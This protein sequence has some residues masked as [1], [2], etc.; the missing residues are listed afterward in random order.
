[1]SL[2]FPQSCGSPKIKSHWPSKSDFLG[3][4][5]SFAS[6]PGW[7]ARYEAQNLHN[8][9]ILWYHMVLQVVSCPLSGY[10]ILFY[11]VCT[12][13]AISLQFPLCLWMYGIFF[14][15]FQHPP[16]DGCS[17]TSCNF[18][19]HRGGEEHRFFC[20]ANLNQNLPLGFRLVPSS[21]E[22][23]LCFFILINLLRCGVHSSHCRIVV[24][25]SSICFTTFIR[26]SFGSLSYS[27]QRR[28]RGKWNPNWK[29]RS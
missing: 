12:P 23:T 7:E 29:R 16:V 10:K 22:P 6:S 1:M 13:S 4:S 21:R 9:E 2:C 8:S 17:T 20:S 27:N 5:N 14:A 11:C 24:L 26:H 25:T 19:V 18:G 15:G 28:K 3:I